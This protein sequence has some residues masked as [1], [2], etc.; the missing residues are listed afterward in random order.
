MTWRWASLADEADTLNGS[1]DRYETIP[2]DRLIISDSNVRRRDIVADVDELA[3]SIQQH[4]LQQPIVVQE[5][6]DR[7]EIIIGQRRY[8][9]YRELGRHAIPAKI[10]AKP[11]DEMQAKVASFSENVQ[12]R[13]LAPR[14][15]ADACQYLFERLGSVRAVAEHLGVTEPTVRKWLGYA[16]VPETLKELVE[17]EKISRTQAVRLWETQEEKKAVEIAELIG[18]RKPPPED[19]RRILTAAEEM[20]DRSVDVILRRAEQ[21]RHETQITFILPEK[22]SRAIDSAAKQLDKEPSEIARDATIEW[23]QRYEFFADT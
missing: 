19:Q 2:L 8:L 20:P 21:L 9:A 15:K 12:R 13:E 4:G 10:L 7:F 11:L 14:D 18:E 23:L 22:W 6:G 3:R 17:Q 16:A 1:A 5:K